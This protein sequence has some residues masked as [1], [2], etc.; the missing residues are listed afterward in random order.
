MSD[1]VALVVD[2]FRRAFELA[3][4]LK[5]NVLAKPT[6]TPNPKSPYTINMASLSFMERGTNQGQHK[7]REVSPLPK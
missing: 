7:I 2:A 5:V 1:K 3:N 6:T 4:E